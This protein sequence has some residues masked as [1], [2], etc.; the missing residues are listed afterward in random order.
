MNS[1][2]QRIVVV[3]CSGSGKTYVAREL[4]RRMGIPYICNDSIIW[5]PNWQPTLREVRLERFE[6]ATAGPA[7]TY[8]GNIGSLKHP[9]HTLILE[10]ADTLV[11][12]D[13][14]LRQVLT[15]VMLRTLR[16]VLFRQRLWHGNVE[17]FS[18]SFLSRESI[19]WWA[20]R[21]Y[22]HRKRQYSAL[23]TNE[24]SAHLV[25]IRLASRREV[26]RFLRRPARR[27]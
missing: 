23:M 18:A 16:R 4:A 25:R 6:E 12:L 9:E 24:R 2:G 15:Q 7:W 17:T 1:C 5:G 21:T 20:I 22:R 19:I 11:W 26:D 14:P 8:D 10:R 27:L 13:L 3:G